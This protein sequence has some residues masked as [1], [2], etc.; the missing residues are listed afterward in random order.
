MLFLF[1]PPNTHPSTP[2]CSRLNPFIN[3]KGCRNSLSWSGRPH[4][5]SVTL[6]K[7]VP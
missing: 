5:L 7:R 2:G 1:V 6:R 3:P 4:V